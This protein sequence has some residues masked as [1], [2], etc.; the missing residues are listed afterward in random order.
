LI[1]SKFRIIVLRHHALT[2]KH[3]RLAIDGK[4]LLLLNLYIGTVTVETDGIA[5][6]GN[7]VDT[8]ATGYC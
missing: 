1:N 3:A 6:T 7:V 2:Q 5:S 4:V 8:G